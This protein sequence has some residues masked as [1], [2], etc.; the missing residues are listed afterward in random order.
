M[1]TAG[2]FLP[3]AAVQLRGMS[4]MVDDQTHMRRR[5]YDGD[6][7]LPPGVTEEEVAFYN[8]QRARDIRVAVNA[9]TRRHARRALVGYFV[10][11]LAFLGNVLYAQHV[12][13]EGREAIVKSG[14]IIAIDGCNRDYRE[15]QEVRQVLIA[16][17]QFQEGAL[18]RGDISQIQH[19][20]AIDFYNDRLEG[21]PLPDCRRAG[22]ILTDDPDSL[23]RMPEPLYP[24]KE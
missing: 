4:H 18:K 24:G 22:D 3:L 11:F 15:R 5:H 1:S 23:T 9:A 16:S 2:M 19:D 13:R 17:R 8:A 10:M 12:A 7:A 20:R 14:D 21:L 6:G